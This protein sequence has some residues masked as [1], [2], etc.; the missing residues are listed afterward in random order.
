MYDGGV[1]GVG[2]L[3]CKNFANPEGALLTVKIC[4]M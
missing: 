2:I 1:E 4:N 3:Q